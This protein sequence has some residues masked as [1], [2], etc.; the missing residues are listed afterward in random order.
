MLKQTDVKTFT[1]KEVTGL[2]FLRRSYRKQL[3]C[4][5]EFER[6]DAILRFLKKENVDSFFLVNEFNKKQ[7]TVSNIHIAV[8]N[9]ENTIKS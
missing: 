9:I 3:V 1:Y 8:L 2:E 7:E 4:K 5:H 6:I